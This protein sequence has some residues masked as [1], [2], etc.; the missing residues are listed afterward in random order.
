MKHLDAMALEALI[1]G[2]EDLASS[3]AR[4]HLEVCADCRAIVEGERE[5]LGETSVALRRASPELPDLDA[6]IARAMEA[7]PSATAPSRR[8]LWM[9][10][11]IGGAAALVMGWL[12]LSSTSL[13]G[14]STMGR[15]ALTLGRALD[16]VVV[17]SVPGGWVGIGVAGLAVAIACALPLRLLLGG[18]RLSASAAAIGLA[19]LVSMPALNARAYRVEGE[20]PDRRVSLQVDGKPTS[21]ALRMAIEAAGLGLVAQLPDDRPVTLHVR[22]V[23][24]GEVV[25]ALLGDADVVVSP[26]ANLVTVRPESAAPP[27]VPEAPA[28]LQDRVTFGCGAAVREGEKVRDVVTMGGD[29]RVAG[30]AYGDVVTMGGDADVSGVV[31]GDVVTMGGDIRV[32]DG[33]R[34]HGSLEAMGGSLDVDPGAFVSGRQASSGPK[35]WAEQ[36]RAEEDEGTIASIFRSG[37]W[38][39]LLF[40]IG[41]VMLGT[42]REQ[43]GNL[44]D[45][46]AA[47]PVQ[48]GLVGLF[49]LLAGGVLCVVLCVTII[50]I[51][52]AAVLA[53]LGVAAMVAGWTTSAFWLGSVLPIKA[54]K[55]RPVHQLGAGIVALFVAGLVPVLG[56]LIGV[57]ALLAGVGAVMATSFGRKRPSSRP[58]S[59]GPFR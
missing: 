24:I 49:G 12:S 38:H 18:G 16:A 6:M 13:S 8:S 42:M 53:A 23:P 47:R 1:T 30:H 7:A 58:V 25:H 3:D 9:G 45:E 46:I 59:V 36:E 56:S 20:W 4:A 26:T 33:A 40:L 15:Q 48:S 31:V 10:G 21:E 17:S 35:E 32:R 43:V 41:L 28:D 34:V 57:A 55:D 37:L 44:R 2:R 19:L 50:G 14:A 54:L 22:D 27:A 39:A 5:M 11:A 29:V 51:P 52:V